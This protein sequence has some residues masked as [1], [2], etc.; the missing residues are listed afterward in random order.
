MS[1]ELLELYQQKVEEESLLTRGH[2]CK[3]FKGSA[4]YELLAA[5]MQALED[6][7]LS[8]LRNYHGH[9]KDENF[10]LTLRWQERRRFH[11]Q[12]LEQIDINIDEAVAT[13]E[14]SGGDLEDW[15]MR[16]DIEH[17]N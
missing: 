6:D 15:T 13:V 9:D 10:A 1:H 5:M 14:Q 16:S 17:G 8:R 2:L 7:A 4:M 12:L 3:A 11:E